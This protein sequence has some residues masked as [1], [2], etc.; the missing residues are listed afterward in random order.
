MPPA[1][2][3]VCLA[4]LL[5]AACAKARNYADPG[6]PIVTGTNGAAPVE[7][8]RKDELRVVTFNVK[9][10]KRLDRAVALLLRPGPLRGADVLVLQEMDGPATEA[11][12]GALGMNHAYVP[13]AVHPAEDRDFG[14]AVLSPWPLED[15]AKVPLPHEHRFIKTRRAAVVVT[16]RLPSG[17]VRVYGL[18]LESPLGLGGG[19]RREQ[20]RAVAEHASAWSGPVVVAGD[21]NGRG[22]AEELA[23]AGFVWLTRHVKNTALFFDMDHVLARG[24][25]AG[26]ERAAGAEDDATDASDHD[27][28]WAVL[29][30]CDAGS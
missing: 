15:P 26:G 8:D 2:S 16:V 23:K 1:R 30:P 13:S 19:D 4:L 28:V 7:G 6:G 25:C 11:I 17:P 14:V 12:A 18:H 22:G 27:P 29:R 21:F 20:A 24:L 9:F 10:A 5:A 3:S